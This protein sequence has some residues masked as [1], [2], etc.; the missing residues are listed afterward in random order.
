MYSYKHIIDNEKINNSILL[1]VV[2][3]LFYIR[4]ISWNGDTMFIMNI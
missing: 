3:P 4:I 1:A 2:I